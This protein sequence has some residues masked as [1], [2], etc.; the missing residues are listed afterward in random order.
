MAFDG[1]RLP[2]SHPTTWGFIGLSG[3]VPRSSM[4][5]CHSSLGLLSF[6]KKALVMLLE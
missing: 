1:I 4:S 2:S 3:R 6:L 5:F